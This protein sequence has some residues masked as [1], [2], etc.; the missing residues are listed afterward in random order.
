MNNACM[1]AHMYS[2]V[3][4]GE[5]GGAGSVSLPAQAIMFFCLHPKEE[6][7][8]RG[9]QQRSAASMQ[10]QMNLVHLSTYLYEMH[11][12]ARSTFELGYLQQYRTCIYMSY[13]RIITSRRRDHSH[14]VINSQQFR[15]CTYVVVR[16]LIIARIISGIETFNLLVF[17]GLA[18]IYSTVEKQLVEVLGIC[19]QGKCI[20]Y[21]IV[22]DKSKR[23]V[24]LLM[25]KR[26]RQLAGRTP[27]LCLPTCMYY[28]EGFCNLH[29]LTLQQYIFI[30]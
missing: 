11:T 4:Q 25:G 6:S 12:A 23:S 19:F 20:T 29:F 28:M 18:Y 15:N 8:D 26:D 22:P 24:L 16:I 14:V 1:H 3:G 21:I 5:G 30:L 2:I 13:A 9:R 10:N 27:T 17:R 7:E